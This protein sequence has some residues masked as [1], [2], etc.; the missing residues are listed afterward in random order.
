MP[1]AFEDSLANGANLFVSISLVTI[2]HCTG[3]AGDLEVNNK[4]KQSL[5][6][7]CCTRGLENLGE[8]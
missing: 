6:K 8:V 3:T 5:A 4:T 7:V 1:W 2:L